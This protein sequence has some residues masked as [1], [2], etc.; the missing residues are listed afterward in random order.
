MYLHAELSCT[1]MIVVI[2]IHDVMHPH[3]MLHVFS[4][5]ITDLSE[6][7]VSQLKE[8]EGMTLT[9]MRSHR[10]PDWSLVIIYGQGGLKS[11]GIKIF[12]LLTCVY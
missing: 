3:V 11:G 4:I 1:H 6:Q 8:C 12:L 7:S 5:E 10:C 9:S 2:Y